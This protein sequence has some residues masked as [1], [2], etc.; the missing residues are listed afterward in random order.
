MVDGELRAARRC[1]V[2]PGHEIVG[3]VGALGAGVERLRRRRPRRRAVAGLAPAATASTAARG[4][5]NL[6][7][8]ARVH[9]LTRCDGGYAEHDAWPTRATCSRCPTATTTSRPRRCCAPA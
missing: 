8:A 7:D 9:R 5:E 4:R 6:C 2:V 1:R 3:R